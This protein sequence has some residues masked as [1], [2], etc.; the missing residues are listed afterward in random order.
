MKFLG[1]KISGPFT[2]PSGIV[3]TEVP[4]LERVAKEIKEIGIL[5]T[6]SIG[7]EKREGNKEPILTNFAPLSFL[8]AVGLANPG[9][10]EFKR[11]IS[12]ISPLKNKFLLISIFGK[13]EKEFSEIA[14]ELSP[15][16]DGF[17]LNLSCPHSQKYGQIVS[18]DF[19]LITKIVKKVKNKGKP[20]FVKISPNIEYQNMVKV[21]LRAGADGIVAIN[22][23]GPGLY[24]KDGFPILLNKF[25][26][27][28]GKAILPVGLKVVREIRKI[29]NFPIIACGGISNAQ[30]VLSYQKVGADFFGIGSALFK[31]DFGEIKNYF[32]ALNQDLKEGTNLAE[33]FLHQEVEDYTKFQITEKIFLTKDLFLLKLDGRIKTFPR[34]F[35]FLWLPEVGEKP[36]SIFDDEPLTFLIRKVGPFTKKLSKLKR[37]D[38]IYLRGPYGKKINLSGK[39]LLCG[40]GTGIA[41]LLLFAKN[42]K[43]SALLSAEESELLRFAKKVFQKWTQKI[44]LKRGLIAEILTDVIRK[45]EPNFILNCGP[46]DMIE[47]VIEIERKLL[48]QKRIYFSSNFL[49]KCGIG[50]CGSCATNKGLR[51]CVDGPFL[52]ENEF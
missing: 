4:I 51:L 20:I 48:P 21:L 11:E 30:D 35:V 39:I 42:Y 43:T 32:K 8:N 6:K 29:G 49:T 47:N 25:G 22:T 38:S 5:T 52:K 23:V 10:K 1:K 33:K 15:F 41:P 13:D 28:S 31:M 9:F 45:E 40:G 27:I 26:G 18:Q 2:I 12:Q 7:I 14:K 16:A 36:F 24:L 46:K 50:L 37:G 34:T 3:T 19:K 17:E 44:Y